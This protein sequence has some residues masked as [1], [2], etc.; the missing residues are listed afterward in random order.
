[1]DIRDLMALAA[2]RVTAHPRNEGCKFYLN[3]DTCPAVPKLS[4]WP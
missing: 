3:E 4:S 2:Q 1:V